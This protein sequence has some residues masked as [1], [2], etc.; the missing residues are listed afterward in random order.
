MIT[1]MIICLDLTVDNSHS[2]G[3]HSHMTDSQSWNSRMISHYPS[4]PHM[5][6]RFFYHKICPLGK[7]SQHIF[8]EI[9]G[10]LVGHSSRV[11][12]GS[13]YTLCFHSHPSLWISFWTSS[14]KESSS[15]TPVP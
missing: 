9:Y 2:V 13:L 4:V 7:S 10:Q 14:C 8:G 6:T 1:N 15:S 11:C 12:L 5:I 3:H